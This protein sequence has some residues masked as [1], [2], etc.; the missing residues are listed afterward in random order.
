MKVAIFGDI[1]GQYEWLDRLFDQS[2]R[3]NIDIY[4]CHGDIARKACKHDPEK[5]MRCIYFMKEKNV[6]CLRG[7]HEENIIKHPKAGEEDIVAF[8]SSLPRKLVFDDLELMISHYSPK[9]RMLIKPEPDEFDCLESMSPVRIAVF[10]HSHIRFHHS[11][12]D[13]IT[14]NYH[15]RFDVPYDVSTG[16]HLINT[17]TANFAFPFSFNLFPG[18][19]IY[20]SD[21]KEIIFK[22]I[23]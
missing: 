19:V 23:K 5:T 1:N 4:S 15:P 16:L 14:A 2:G 9:G 6:Q 8:F 7:N 17:G 21:T 3:Y 13:K 10:G 12:T 11:R 22:K 20:D 18:Y